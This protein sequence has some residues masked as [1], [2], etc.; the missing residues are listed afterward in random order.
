MFESEVIRLAGSNGSSS[1]EQLAGLWRLVYSSGFAS[2]GST[3]GSRPGL[4]VNLLPAQLGQARPSDPFADHRV[5]ASLP[6]AAAALPR[7]DTSLSDLTDVSQM[8]EW[9]SSWSTRQTHAV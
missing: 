6:S 1:V 9:P 8:A 3:G 5:L 2:S 4:P 7:R